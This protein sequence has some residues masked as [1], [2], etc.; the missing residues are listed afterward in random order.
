MADR[1]LS[2]NAK[3]REAELTGAPALLRVRLTYGV[4]AAGEVLAGFAGGTL[5]MDFSLASR[6]NVLFGASGA[7]KSTLLRLLAGLL[8]PADGIVVLGDRLL[9]D[10]A[11]GIAIPAGQRGIGYLTQE[12]A[13]FPHLN[14]EA[15]I[16]YGLHGMPRDARSERVAAMLALFSLEPFARRLPERLSGGE[17]QRVALARALAPDPSLL[18]LDEAF[19]GLDA[20]LRLRMATALEQYLQGRQT[21][22]LAVSHDV[23]EVY[24]G[25]AEVLLLEGGRITEQGP[26][27]QV[28]A[29]HRERLLAQLGVASGRVA[30][31]VA[32]E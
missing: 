12:P 2:S 14:V 11:A 13:L 18:L 29:E 8:R 31:F 20:P 21:I 15:N 3:A 19:S 9:T 32:A 5:H 10:T 24:S 4:G 22:V 23:A 17:R 25:G 7:G 16:A 28:L 30:P 6:R 27:Q 1:I 26:A